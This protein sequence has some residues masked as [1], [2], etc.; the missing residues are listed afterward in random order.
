MH[1]CLDC[2]NVEADE[3][4]AAGKSDNRSKYM[5][6]TCVRSLLRLNECAF[7]DGYDLGSRQTTNLS[8]KHQGHSYMLTVQRRT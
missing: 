7:L 4:A 5:M 2:G 1:I 3:T 8:S 6:A